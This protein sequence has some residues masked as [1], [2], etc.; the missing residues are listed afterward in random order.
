MI[1]LELSGEDCARIALALAVDASQDEQ[2]AKDA[3]SSHP[4]IHRLKK[5]WIQDAIDK[6]RIAEY[7][8]REACK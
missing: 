6:R 5:T 2:R 8:T 7:V 1:K 4:S 3:I